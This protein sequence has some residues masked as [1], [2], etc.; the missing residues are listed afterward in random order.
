MGLPDTGEEGSR[1]K[2]RYSGRYVQKKSRL[3]CDLGDVSYGRD[4]QAGSK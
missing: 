2:F 1:G 4:A 3:S